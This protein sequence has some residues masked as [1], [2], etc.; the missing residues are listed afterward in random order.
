MKNIKYMLPTALFLFFIAVSC[1][2]NNT[3]IVDVDATIGITVSTR[4]AT[5]NMGWAGDNKFIT[6]AIYI[7]DNTTGV[8]E[9]SQLSTD[10]PNDTKSF[11]YKVATG[12]KSVYVIGNYEDKVLKRTDNSPITIN[13]STTKSQLDD[14]IV[15]SFSDF[16]P[17]SLLMIGKEIVSLTPTDHNKNVNIAMHH[18]QA[19]IDVHL[20]K[21]EKIASKDVVIESITLHN[22]ILNS[23]VEFG[24]STPIMLP[25]PSY[26]NRATSF[27]P[28]QPLTTLP[29]TPSITPDNAMAIFYSYQNLLSTP[30]VT[31][32][33]TARLEVV[34]KI[35]GQ[36]FTFNSFITDNS[37]TLNKYDLR[38]NNIYAITGILDIDP[39]INL[40]LIVLPWNISNIS[41]DRPITTDDFIFAPVA[42][43]WGGDNGKVVYTNSANV[44]DAAFTF[45]LKAP[46]GASWRATLTNGL[47]FAFAPT[48]SGVATNCVSSGYTRP[49]IPYTIAVKAISR[50]VGVLRD[51]EFYIT[52][53]GREIDINPLVGGL[54]KY[55]G[56]DTRIII[57]QVASKN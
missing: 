30:G 4:A 8:L 47:H 46:E 11:S 2:K 49:D 13:E 16:A 7:F 32:A 45:E 33:S 35:D 24:A 17:E 50:W 42:L 44:E 15:E 51:T 37:Q 26:A 34:A 14:M 20:F 48:T 38:Q 43:N 25:Y 19:R 54:R 28:S 3:K 22:Q 57:K 36:P 56:T 27:S 41:I 12:T 39:K 23:E 52:V 29:L 6:L 55:E 40:N 5:D 18:L 9:A 10:L 21:G 1:T 53:E 31:T